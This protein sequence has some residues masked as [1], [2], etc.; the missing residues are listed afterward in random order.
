V[1][2]Y[3]IVIFLAAV[4]YRIVHGTILRLIEVAS[5]NIFLVLKVL[6]VLVQF[7]VAPRAARRYVWKRLV[8]HR[9]IG[10]D[11]PRMPFLLLPGSPR[12]PLYRIAGK[13]F[14]MVYTK[15]SAQRLSLRCARP[16]GRLSFPVSLSLF[17]LPL[18]VLVKHHQ[19]MF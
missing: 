10:Q 8:V 11:V 13:Q 16:K 15:I 7:S 3:V 14:Q 2:L 1:R 12:L 4:I 5:A 6:I 17:S 18:V 9:A 19:L